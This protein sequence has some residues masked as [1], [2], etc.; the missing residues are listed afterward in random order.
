MFYKVRLPLHP[1]VV[2]GGGSGETLWGKRPGSFA[3]FW[4][5]LPP[6]TDSPWLQRSSWGGELAA[7]LRAVPTTAQ[8]EA[9]CLLWGLEEH[10]NCQVRRLHVQWAWSCPWAGEAQAL[11]PSLPAGFCLRRQRRG[12]W[13]AHCVQKLPCPGRGGL[14]RSEWDPNPDAFPVHLPAMLGLCGQPAVGRWV[15]LHTSYKWEGGGT[16]WQQG[17]LSLSGVT[18]GSPLGLALWE[19]RIN[20]AD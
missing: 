6:P 5:P 14:G 19:G 3:L 8:R 11:T 16:S 2:S 20:T 13:G 4:V 7:V 1:D 15:G 17:P 10:C 9:G 18:S 12:C